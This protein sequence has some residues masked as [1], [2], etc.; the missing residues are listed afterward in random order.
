[1]FNY[2][3]QTAQFI[4]AVIQNMPDIPGDVMQSWIENPKGLQRVLESVL[5]LPSEVRVWRTIEL[6]IGPKT[7]DDLRSALRDGNLRLSDWASDIF[8]KPAFAVATEETEVDLVK[9]T[10]AELGFKQGAKSDQIYKRAKELGLELCPAEV[11]PQ[12]R[13]Q[14]KDQ[15]KGEWL[16][17]GMEPIL[18]SNGSPSTFSLGLDA[19]GLNAGYGGPDAFSRADDR[20]VFVRPRK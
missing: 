9:V 20:W 19:M 15:P 12:L 13:L 8:G 16:L 7:V 10:V 3:G 17:I 4:A 18:D 2:H 14:Y 5:R 1:M 11:G 6:G